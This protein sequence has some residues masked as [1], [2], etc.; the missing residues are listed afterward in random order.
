MK[1]YKGGAKKER[2]KRAKQMRLEAELTKT[3]KIH[4]FFS[5]SG[6][7]AADIQPPTASCDIQPPTTA[8]S[9]GDI[10]P[11]TTAGDIQPPTASGDIQPPGNGDVDAQ[12]PIHFGASVDDLAKLVREDISEQ[13]RFLWISK[14]SSNCQHEKGPF[15]KSMR[16]DGKVKRWCT[17][18]MFHRIHNKTGNQH[19]RD[20]L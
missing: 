12:K 8:A 1:R 17:Q 20:W 2:D 16:I 5:S 14:G 9:A 3:S 18:S 7:S 10:Q 19:L 15:N 13:E 11:P 4:G 6:T